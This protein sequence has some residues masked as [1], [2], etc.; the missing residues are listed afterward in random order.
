MRNLRFWIAAV[1]FA[2][3]VTS[4][5]VAA[6]TVEVLIEQGAEAIEKR[7]YP[8]ALEIWQRVVELDPDNA[9]AHSN[10]W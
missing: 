10:L 9:V 6:Q 3:G 8:A 4:G 1:V 2:L 5:R 7:D